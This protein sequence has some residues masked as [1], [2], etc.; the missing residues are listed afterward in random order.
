MC[1]QVGKYT[2]TASGD[3]F[4]TTRLR[5]CGG[6]ASLPRGVVTSYRNLFLGKDANA[7]LT[8]DCD[9]DSVVIERKRDVDFRTSCEDTE[10]RL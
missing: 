10:N 2:N 3:D 9:E 5:F 7:N 6:S 1:D 8:R 4:S